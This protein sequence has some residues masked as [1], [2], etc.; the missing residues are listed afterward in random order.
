MELGAFQR[1]STA[2]ECF[3]EAMTFR[4]RKSGVVSERY[5][6]GFKNKLDQLVANGTGIGEMLGLNAT[7]GLTSVTTTN[8]TTG[9]ATVSDYEGLLFGVAKAY[10][11]EA[12]KSRS[13]FLTN[14]VTYRR[15]RG[16]AVGTSDQR[17]VYG[18]DHES[19]MTHDH[20]HKISEQMANTEAGFFC[21]NRYRA[22]RRQGYTVRI[23]T[24]GATLANKNQQLI[25][26][27]ARFGGQLELG[28]AGSRATT[29][30]T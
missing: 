9:P 1:A 17:R 4:S 19:Y 22:Y 13:V 14:D 28:A 6:E 25:I 26:V 2:E 3:N 12:G 21:L 11:Q 7:T 20:P 18:M 16:I 27:R 8:N 30:Q 5:S 29:M 15:L 23:E 10:R 24:A